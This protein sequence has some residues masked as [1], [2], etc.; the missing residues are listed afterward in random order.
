MVAMVSRMS[1]LLH[2][3]TGEIGLNEYIAHLSDGGHGIA[4]VPA[5]LPLLFP[6]QLQREY[7]DRRGQGVHH[8]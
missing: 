2:L 8:W 6:P 1:R 4:D 3:Y 7:A 5:I